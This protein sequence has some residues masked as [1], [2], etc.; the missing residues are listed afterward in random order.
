MSQEVIFIAVPV[1]EGQEFIAETLR[2][3]RDQT[4][5]SYRVLISVD[6]NDLVSAEVCKSF[7]ND[8]R[9]DMV[10]HTQ[11]LGWARNFNWLIQQCDCPFFIYWQQDDLASTNYLEILH[12]E[13]MKNTSASIAYTD[14][15]WFGAKFDRN[16][17]PSIQGDPQERVFQAIEDISFIPLRGLIRGDRLK[18]SAGIPLAGDDSCHAEFPFL[19]EMAAL[20]EFQH[21]SDA[22]YFKRAHSRNAFVRWINWQPWKRRRAWIEMGLGF[23]RVAQRVLQTPSLQQRVLVIILDR[24]AISRPGRA[25]FYQPPTAGIDEFVRDFLVLGKLNDADYFTDPECHDLDTSVKPVDDRI[26]KA[27]LTMDRMKAIRSDVGNGL[28]LTDEVVLETRKGAD[29]VSMLGFGWSMVESW[30]VWS[31]GDRA[32]LLL[33]IKRSGRYALILEGFH[34]QSSSHNAEKQVSVLW[35]TESQKSFKTNTLHPG[36]ETR[37]NLEFECEFLRDDIPLIVELQF[38]D[39]VFLPDHGIPDHRKV[40]FG[41]KKIR[42]LHLMEKLDRDD[43][44]KPN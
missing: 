41:L 25:F 13:L 11:Q 14:V 7:L 30:G 22:M 26:K 21:S 15:Q 4:F 24:L 19:V 29:G 44:E 3:I 5:T 17:V 39:S 38:P 10:V 43:R 36:E 9:F 6:N 28:N 35:R 20:G 40:G 31:D 23:L 32:T 27:Y 34:Y 2:S 12:A 18:Q 33:P 42:I 8:P 1:F 16:S 37:L